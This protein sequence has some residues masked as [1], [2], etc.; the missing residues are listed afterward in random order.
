MINVDP[1]EKQLNRS[2]VRMRNHYGDL[3]ALVFVI[4]L[5]AF[6]YINFNSINIIKTFWA[7]GNI[8][9]VTDDSEFFEINSE[10]SMIRTNYKDQYH[11][12]L[13]LNLTNANFIVDDNQT[14]LIKVS[15][16]GVKRTYEFKE[17]SLFGKDYILVV[18][19]EEI[20]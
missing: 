9:L 19:T 6:S 5:L 2:K 4:A 16:D 13:I 14:H 11:T 18:M 17:R 1:T 20:E 8:A 12:Q 10:T 3:W 7:Y 15:K